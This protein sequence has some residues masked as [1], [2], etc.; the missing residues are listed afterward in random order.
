MLTETKNNEIIWG[1]T[2]MKARIYE[3]FDEAIGDIF[4][5]ASLMVFCWGVTGTPQNLIRALRDRGTKDLTLIS[6]NLVPAFV[7]PNI[8]WDVVTPYFLADQVKKLITAW[9]G[10]SIIGLESRME[11][12]IRGGKTELELV[13]HGILVQRI[14][15]GGSG[16]GGFYSP[17]GIG[18][19]VEEGKERK[20]IDGREY[21]LEKPLKADFGFVRAYKADRMGNLVYR[22]GGRACNPIIAMASRVTIAEVDEIVEVGE[23]DPEVIVTPG[24]FVDRIVE[25]PEGGLGSY[26]ERARILRDICKGGEG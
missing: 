8:L 15:A 11:E 5:G 22:G 7:G 25:V 3:S 13:S 9:P 14:R 10:T 26:K 24:I 21:I 17:I 23:L 19:V 18:T 20:V 12:R 16:I 1:E 6:H 2:V 4:D